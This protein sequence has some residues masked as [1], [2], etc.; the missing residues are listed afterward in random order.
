M[1]TAPRQTVLS[2]TDHLAARLDGII[3]EVLAPHLNG[4]EWTSILVELDKLKGKSPSPITANDLQSQLRVMTE[5]LGG[6]GFPFDDGA[7]TVSTLASDLRTVRRNLAHTNPFTRLEAWRAAD[8]CVRLLEAF[9][10]SDGIIRAT[11][12]RHD[13]FL[14]YAE[15]SGL[16]PGPALPESKPSPRSATGVAGVIESDDE[17]VGTVE[18][19]QRAVEDAVRGD[20][21]GLVY[22]PW[23][24]DQVGDVAVL[25]TIARNE[26]KLKVR[27][28]AEEI[29]DF[30][31]PIGLDRLAGE[32]ARGFGLKKVVKERKKRIERQI[33]NAGVF[34]DE[35][36][37]VWPTKSDALTWTAYRVDKGARPRNFEEIS[38]R[39]IANALRRVRDDCRTLD[40]DAQEL[41]VLRAFQREKKTRGVR[42]QLD[43]AWELL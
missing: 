12:I 16:G 24:G 7:R 31:W 39:E 32:V 30:E 4:L 21:G 6:L 33:L 9:G 23:P 3:G 13:A 18:V 22:E 15:E 34:V 40:D 38:P 41:A 42:H 43:L 5:R 10:D 11:E 1:K 14:A 27:A 8:H 35:H 20:Q 28:L 25:D 36:G 19:R 37:F 29:V 26:S 2:A 17:G